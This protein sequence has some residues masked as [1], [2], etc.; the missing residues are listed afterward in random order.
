MS[1]FREVPEA[2][3][4]VPLFWMP[5]HKQTVM[6]PSPSLTLSE[7]I[8]GCGDETIL[9]NHGPSQVIN[10]GADAGLQKMSLPHGRMSAMTWLCSHDWILTV[11]FF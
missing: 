3:F 6:R 7:K 5:G 4:A 2:A 11:R 8:K 9:H 10:P 1:C